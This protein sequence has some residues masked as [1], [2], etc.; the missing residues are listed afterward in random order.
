MI[1]LVANFFAGVVGM[2]II[3]AMGVVAFGAK[4]AI[5]ADGSQEALLVGGSIIIGGLVALFSMGL[6]CVL[7]D[8]MFNVRKLSEKLN[9]EQHNSSNNA[10]RA[11]PELG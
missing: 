1:K 8:I 2:L 5:S 4:I 3:S 7:L 11:E 9:F 10:P 6:S